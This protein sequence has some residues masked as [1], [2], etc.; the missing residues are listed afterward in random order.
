[1]P[2]TG[3][4]RSNAAVSCAKNG[5]TDRLPVL[6]VDSGGLKE[7]QVESYLSGGANVHKFSR[8]RQVAPMCQTTLHR[9]LYENG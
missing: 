2:N 4:P 5:L 7:V 8:V 9:E 6:I 1:M 3:V